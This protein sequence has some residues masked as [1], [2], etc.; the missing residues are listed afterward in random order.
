MKTNIFTLTKNKYIL[1]VLIIVLSL[2]LFSCSSAADKVDEED[3]IIFTVEELSQYDG[4]NGQ[5][6]Y[7]AIDGNVYDVTDAQPWRGGTHNGFQA[8]K[9][10]THEMKNISPH[11][12][13][14]LRGLTIIGKLAEDN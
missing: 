2:L 4:Q 1:L 10:L 14:K 6:A 11:G 12:V 8:G 13:T 5:K 3:L 7:I 9:D